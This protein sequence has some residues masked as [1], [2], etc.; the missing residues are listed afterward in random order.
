[1]FFP[2]MTRAIPVS[3][4]GS[5]AIYCVGVTPDDFAIGPDKNRVRDCSGP[6]ESKALTGAFVSGSLKM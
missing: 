2:E 4:R 3:A 1:M 6:L 5:Q